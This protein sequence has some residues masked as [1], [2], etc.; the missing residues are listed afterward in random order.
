MTFVRIASV[1]ILQGLVWNIED[2]HKRTGEDNS[3]A[4]FVRYDFFKVEIMLQTR[5]PVPNANSGF[6]KNSKNIHKYEINDKNWYLDY[7]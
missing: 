4:I 1:L 2:I 5:I 3:F 6:D 7:S